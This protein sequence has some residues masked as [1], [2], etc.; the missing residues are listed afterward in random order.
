MEGKQEKVTV[1]RRLLNSLDTKNEGFSGRKLSAVWGN[2]L[3]G[4]LVVGYLVIGYQ[5]DNFKNFPLVLGITYTYASL[6]LGL[7]TASN[8]IHFKH[9]RK[10]KELPTQQTE[11]GN[12]GN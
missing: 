4:A 6:C 1:W 2:L 10:G 7:V 5:K 9:G 8:I 12:G 11:G 3:A